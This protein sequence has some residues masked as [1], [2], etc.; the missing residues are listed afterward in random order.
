MKHQWD[1]EKVE[2]EQGSE[3]VR[4]WMTMISD[5]GGKLAGPISR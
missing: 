1:L 2:K 3:N 5:V 4:N